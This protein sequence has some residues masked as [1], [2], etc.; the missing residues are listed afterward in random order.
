MDQPGRADGGSR[1]ARRRGDVEAVRAGRSWP[2]LVLIL[3]LFL[4]EVSVREECIK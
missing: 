1:G 3:E 2:F 4:F